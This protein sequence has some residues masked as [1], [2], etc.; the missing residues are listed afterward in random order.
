L[1]T[2]LGGD[3]RKRVTPMANKLVALGAGALALL[4]LSA[5]HP[6]EAPRSCGAHSFRGPVHRA[7]PGAF[8][9]PPFAYGYYNYGYGYWLW[10]WLL[11]TEEQCAPHR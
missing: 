5:V 9:G 4:T 7:E 8:V 6:A 3:R 2:T 1:Q 10:L 11:L